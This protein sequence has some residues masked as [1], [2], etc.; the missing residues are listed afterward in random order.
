M[1]ST[2]FSSHVPFVSSAST[3]P[4]HTPDFDLHIFMSLMP[5]GISQ[6]PCPSL[7]PSP[8]SSPAVAARVLSS[9]LLSTHPRSHLISPSQDPSF[10]TYSSISPQ[11]SHHQ[12]WLAPSPAQHFIARVCHGPNNY[13]TKANPPPPTAA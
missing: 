13:A 10:F 6:S 4:S 2:V 12:C 1:T 8:L 7:I 9:L 11:F 5:F 3:P